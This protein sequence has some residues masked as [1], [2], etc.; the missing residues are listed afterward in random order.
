MKFN[1]TVKEFENCEEK[2]M[3]EIKLT[4]EQ[5]MEICR[6]IWRN[7][8]KGEDQMMVI[9]KQEG[10]IVKDE[11]EEAINKLKEFY[12]RYYLSAG[13]NEFHGIKYCA[14]KIIELLQ[15]K[16]KELEK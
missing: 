13:T 10:W 1:K 15:N 3:S 14:D 11:I 12:D 5:F 4:E 8:D 2:A 7:P 9:A 16:I 6:E